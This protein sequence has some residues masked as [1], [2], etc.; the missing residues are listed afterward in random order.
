MILCPHRL[1]A[2]RFSFTHFSARGALRFELR[3]VVPTPRPFLQKRNWLFPVEFNAISES[4]VVSWRQGNGL[5]KDRFVNSFERQRSMN[6]PGWYVDYGG[7]L[8]QVQFLFFSHAQLYRG[9]EVEHALEITA[10][11]AKEL[12]KIVRV[13]YAV[14]QR[15]FLYVPPRGGEVGVR[16]EMRFAI[17]VC[18]WVG[19]FDLWSVPQTG[20]SKEVFAIFPVFHY[21]RPPQGFA[22]QQSTTLGA[23]DATGPVSICATEVNGHSRIV[24]LASDIFVMSPMRGRKV[25]DCTRR[26]T[27]RV[28]RLSIM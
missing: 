26:A 16:T 4:A 21:L 8:D 28:S 17:D 19:Q 9:V 5:E 24:P 23:R 10:Q 25:T 22:D 2:T 3:N 12:V 14:K 20:L 1:C 18:A 11:E 27:R 13:R 7:L 15:R 6:Q